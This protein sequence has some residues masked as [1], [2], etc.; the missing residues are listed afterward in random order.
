MIDEKWNSDEYLKGVETC[1]NIVDGYLKFP[2][3]RILDIGCGFAGVSELFQKKYG[4]ELW[5][6][7]GDMSTTLDRPRKAKYGEVTDFKFYLPIEE[8]YRQWDKQ[9][10][11]YNFID[12]NNIQIPDL[13][14]DLVYSWL[15][16]GYHYPFNTYKN[17]ISNHTTDESI[18]LMDFRRKTLDRQLSDFDIIEILEGSQT[19][20]RI[21]IHL[22]VKK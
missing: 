9:N 20:K 4:T 11:Q 12:A 5:L 15:S 14:F 18:I 16:C 21:K 8:L 1:F 2:P 3:K 17:L 10:L 22:K 13:K 19:S 7:D 6:L